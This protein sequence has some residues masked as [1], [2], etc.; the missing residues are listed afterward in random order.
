MSEALSP[1]PPTITVLR[2]EPEVAL[3]VLQGEHDL[4]ST[5]DLEKTLDDAL[6]N[7]SHLI[8]D[9]STT[10]F[11]DST[12]IR[13][14]V[15]AKKHAD[16]TDHAFNVVLA[17]TPIVERA[18]EITN[19]LPILNRVTSLEQALTARGSVRQACLRE[20]AALTSADDRCPMLS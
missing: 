9:L 16:N 20:I 14:L 18:L 6:T 4:A 13:A 5:P 10:E 11:I 3:V 1:T 7:C 8:V 2:P 15:D 17:T 19:V 12:T